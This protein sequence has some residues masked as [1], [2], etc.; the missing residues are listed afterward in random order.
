[1]SFPQ[2]K[3][4]AL[5]VYSPQQILEEF[6]SES[7]V[8][9]YVMVEYDNGVVKKSG[10]RKLALS[11][12]F[13]EFH[14]HYPELPITYDHHVSSVL[15]GRLMTSATHI[16]L[17]TRITE[18]LI[19]NHG[20]RSH[21]EREKILSLIYDV[22]N[23][24]YNVLPTLTGEY[25]AT[26]D[27][28]DIISIVRDSEILA[29]KEKTIATAHSIAEFYS[30]AQKIIM[31][32]ERHQDNSMVQYVRMGLLNMNQVNQCALMR[33][34]PTEVTGAI[35]S[36]PIMS[37]YV[38]GMYKVYDF[39]AESRGAAKHL[40]SAEQPLQDS[41]YF[42]RR[43]QL[44]SMVV[45]GIEEGDCG[46][47]EYVSWL[48][49]GPAMNSAGHISYGGDLPL[50]VGKYR[51]D[52]DTGTLREITSDDTFLIG[53]VIKMRSHMF[54]HLKDPHMVCSTCFGMLS[55]NVSRFANLGH[56][57]C[58]TL[59][60]Q[61]TQSILGTKHLIGSGVGSD[62][63][64]SQ[65]ARRYFH[66]VPKTMAF[67]IRPGIKTSKLS[68]VIPRAAAVGLTDLLHVSSNQGI[69]PARI[70]S[71]QTMEIREEMVEG[72]HVPTVVGVDQNGRP[73]YLSMEFLDYAR[74][75][76]WETDEHENFV[77][78]LSKWALNEPILKIPDVEYSYSDHSKQIAEM[79][80]S[81][82]KDIRLRSRPDAPVRVLQEL[83]D[84]VNSKLSV[85]IAVLETI[86]YANMTAGPNNYAMARNH[87]GA[88][89]NVAKSIIQ[90]RSMGPSLVYEKQT[91]IIT[92]PASFFNEGRPSS[93]LDV[94]FRPK[95]VV[96][97]TKRRGKH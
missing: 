63:M 68:L 31:E 47:T 37:N 4:R 69:S 52:E 82:I 24:I 62:F 65:E 90:N 93:P 28:S 10:V 23:T 54:C 74:N 38:T 50:L 78:D 40:F 48:V 79:I 2:V 89:L 18:Q 72:F 39:V 57:C 35:L 41:E 91:D 75:V 77:F 53:K 9:D 17:L 49:R 80:E 27:L 5:L 42:A 61:S 14:A 29:L 46:S 58:A 86:V 26:V 7:D 13:W 19:R 71:V 33:G 81:K 15:K 60:Q 92:N 56:L 20:H 87:P 25:V 3:A 66:F 85:N 11:R 64:L 22:V 12:F 6:S 45:E 16:N 95:E 83:F 88:G 84:L 36:Q 67:Y 32:N 30:S 43:L 55:I 70:S 34:L 8:P 73:G 76:Q 96:E 1:M 44:V 97:D 21:T 59:T 94:Y 51:L